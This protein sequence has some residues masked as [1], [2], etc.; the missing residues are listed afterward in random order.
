MLHG[1][2]FW[3]TNSS[4]TTNSNRYE[5]VL[6]QHDPEYEFQTALADAMSPDLKDHGLEFRETVTKKQKL[7]HR[8]AIHLQHE[9][10]SH[11]WRKYKDVCVL[12]GRRWLGLRKFVK[13]KPFYSAFKNFGP[14]P[15]SGHF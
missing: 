13:A 3:H 12:E 11:M 9:T 6:Q 8:F 5:A 15:K 7:Q 2:L 14:A 1:S 10:N 4:I